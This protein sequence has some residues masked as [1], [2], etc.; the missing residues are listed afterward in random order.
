METIWFIILA[1]MLIVYSI[2][3][4]F[5][6][7]TGIIYLF[8]ARNDADRRTVL[9]AIGPFWDGNEVW[10]IAAGG[11]LFLAFPS[12]YSA[13][14]S[15]F[16]LAL[17][18]VLWLLILRGISIELRSHLHNPLWSSF[19]DVVFCFSSGLLAFILGVALGNLI[20]GVP[21]NSSGYFFVALWTNFKTGPQPGILDWYTILVGLLSVSLLGLHGAGFIAL[22]TSGK[23]KTRSRQIARQL[24]G[25]ILVLSALATVSTFIIQPDVFRNYRHHPL[26]FV[27]PALTLAALAGIF[28]FSRQKKEAAMFGASSLLIAALMGSAVFSLYPNILM[29][30]YSPEFS[31]T[32]YNASAPT[33]SLRI[34]L[35]WYLPGMLLALGY[36]VFMYRTFRKKI[37]KPLDKAGIE[38]GY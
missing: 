27:L 29:S 33:E 26:G 3:D 23:I 15:G 30:G 24:F 17:F 36:T 4:G 11:A 16:Y 37:T 32:I 12:A 34:A 20:R 22:K 25:V 9:N 8:V 35:M 19:W 6:F 31:L 14:F 10:L 18:I 28:Y 21:L 5:D 7:G 1:A 38:G 13:G 2:L